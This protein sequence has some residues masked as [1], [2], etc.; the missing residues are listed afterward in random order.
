MARVQLELGGK[1]PAVVVEHDDLEGAAREIVSAAFLCSGQRC[2]AI[3]RVIVA[4]NQADEL[5]ER[6]LAQVGR[7]RVG[8]GLEEGTTMGPLVSRGQL[9][10]V[11]S[12]VRRGLE[13][14][15]RLLAGGSRLAGEPDDEGYLYAPTLFDYVAPGSPLAQEE[16]FGPVLPVIRVGGFDEAVEVAN[17]TR[18]GLAA[19]LFTS[20]M[21]LAQAFSRRVRAG[22]IHINHGTASQAHVP[23]GGVKES[24]QGAYSIGYT[25]KDFYTNLK[26]VY[27]KWE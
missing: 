3:S 16:I 9:E 27:V 13:S 17:G 26:T 14:G 15:A 12:Y 20:K 4:Q 23:F 1:N 8:D 6:I 24:G 5:V 18:Y 2:T 11:E 25:A 21:K 10:T 19:A 7:I 22:M